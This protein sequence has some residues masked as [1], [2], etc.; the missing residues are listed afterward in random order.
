MKKINYLVAIGLLFL[1]SL[2]IQAEPGKKNKNLMFIDKDRNG[3]ISFFEFSSRSEKMFSFL[4]QNSDG[5]ITRQEMDGDKNLKK[6]K[7][8]LR[9]ADKLDRNDDQKIDQKEFIAGSKGRPPEP[10]QRPK[11]R[12][13]PK[14]PPVEGKKEVSEAIF[15]ALDKNEDGYLNPEELS[16]GREVGPKVAKD[17]KFQKLDLNSNNMV[18]KEEFI[19][20]L[21][22]RF[23]ALDKNS[24]EVLDRREL[25]NS[26][27]RKKDDK[28]QYK[29][30][31]WK[32]KPPT[33]HRERKRN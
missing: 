14:G 9:K 23:S 4:D 27:E 20:P 6:Q 18:S 30:N 22:K 28:R 31:M 13:P 5:N 3:V 15:K 25:M 17:L 33:M 12:G 26:S 1:L 8:L 2:S 24:D 21:R 29:D 11:R 16:K 32:G 10:R 7:M 19:S